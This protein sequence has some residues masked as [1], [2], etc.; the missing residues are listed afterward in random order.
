[1]KYVYLQEV[2]AEQSWHDSHVQLAHQSDL[3]WICLCYCAAVINTLR[4]EIGLALFLQGL[5]IVNLK[6]HILFQVAAMLVSRRHCVQFFRV[7][8]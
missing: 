8:A 5:D 4:G 2:Q 6:W 1:M 7:L 3:R